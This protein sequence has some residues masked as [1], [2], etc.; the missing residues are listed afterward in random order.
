MFG[1]VAK[2]KTK[3]GKRDEVIKTLMSDDRPVKGMQAAYIY[4]TGADEVFMVGVFA[5][6]ATYRANASDP[7]QDK[8]YRKLRDLLVE[9]PEWHD[10]N[11]VPW[12]GN[13]K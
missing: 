7:E 2:C 4:E 12:P 3:P 13:K 9:D 10:G 11:I 8:E 6:E 5:D 1:T